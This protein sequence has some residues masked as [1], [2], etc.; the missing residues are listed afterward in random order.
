MTS[1]SPPFRF[2]LVARSS[3]GDSVIWIGDDF[4]E[5]DRQLQHRLDSLM[6]GD[7]ESDAYWIERL[8]SDH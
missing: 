5:A 1:F 8:D 4:A 3:D 6:N 7:S 2:R